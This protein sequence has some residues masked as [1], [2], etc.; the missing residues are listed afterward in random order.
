[1]AG[2]HQTEL[3][4]LV[5]A[6]DADAATAT[7]KA[8]E[9]SA[10]ASTASTHAGTATT[11]A[12][13][14]EASALTALNAPGTSATSTTSLTV[15]AGAQALTI[16]TGKSI[17]VG[18]EVA[19]A[20]TTTPTTRMTGTVTAYDTGTGALTVTVSAT[21]GS[22]TY[23]A[24]T[25]SLTAAVPDVATKTGAETL[26]NKTLT[27]PA[28]TNYTETIYAPAAGSA[29]TVDLANGTVQKLTTNANATI[30]LPASV[31]GKSYLLLV[32]YGGTHT[33]TWAGGS[34]IKWS[35]GSAP[36]ATSVNGKFDIFAFTCDGT[37]TYGRTGGS[38]F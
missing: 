8:G 36:A 18:M 4:A 37:A 15:G 28:V 2:T 33:I 23:A 10:S 5:T 13:E 20:Y 11:K 7:T 21:S 29:W 14:A 9:A 17:V 32:A 34:T 1:M 38:N 16:Q 30:T 35:G 19:I 31:A 12:A 25:V 24:W 27:N 22:G 3:D 6:V 26:T